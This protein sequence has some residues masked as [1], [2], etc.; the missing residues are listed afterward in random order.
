MILQFNALSLD[1]T[2]LIISNAY[3]NSTP[4][5]DLMPGVVII[6]ETAPPTAVITYSDTAVRFADTLVISASFSEA[7]DPAVPV[8]LNL[9]GAA[10]LMDAEMT[11]LDELAYGYLFPVPRAGGEVIVTLGNGTDLW[12]NPVVPDPTEG[13]SFSIIP[14]D[15]RGCG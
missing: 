1:T 2:S 10:S 5:T 6:T 8:L 13:G 12:G 15:C 9:E 7:M 4:V 14:F 11:R 3:L